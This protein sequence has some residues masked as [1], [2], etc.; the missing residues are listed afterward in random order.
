MKATKMKKSP[1]HYNPMATDDG[2]DERFLKP[3]NDASAENVAAFLDD[4]L[5][6]SDSAV[7]GEH[8][9]EAEAARKQ[10]LRDQE[11]TSA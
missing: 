8:D 2:Q 9:P 1:R 11:G 10:A 5:A 7:N 3:I 4:L 6:L